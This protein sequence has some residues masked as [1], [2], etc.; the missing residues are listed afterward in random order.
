[1]RLEGGIDPVGGREHDVLAAIGLVAGAV[2]LDVHLVG[3]VEQGLAVLD[4][5][6]ALVRDVPLPEFGERLDRRLVA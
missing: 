5:T 1:M 2:A 3:N 6:G 4:G